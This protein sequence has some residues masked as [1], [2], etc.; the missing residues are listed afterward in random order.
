MK[1]LAGNQESL[2]EFGTNPIGYLK[3]RGISIP[4][5]LELVP[6]LEDKKSPRIDLHFNARDPIFELALDRGWS[7]SGCCVCTIDYCGE[8]CACV[9]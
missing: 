9:F 5:G 6:H 1:E 3:T 7:C 8:Y 4:D 2:T